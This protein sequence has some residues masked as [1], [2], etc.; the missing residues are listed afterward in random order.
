MEAGSCAYAMRKYGACVLTRTQSTYTV[1]LH[2]ISVFKITS[3]LRSQ[4]NM[5]EVGDMKLLQVA[6]KG[7]VYDLIHSSLVCSPVF[8][9][10]ACFF[11][12]KEI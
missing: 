9:E 8:S 4:V 12:E 5:C 7:L 2:F 6:L 10:T 1:C 11:P 3:D